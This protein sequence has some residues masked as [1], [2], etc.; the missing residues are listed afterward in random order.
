MRPI[1]VVLTKL[2]SAIDFPCVPH[3]ERQSS[4]D[5]HRSDVGPSCGMGARSLLSNQRI[6]P[7]E[8]RSLMSG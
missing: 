4:Q 8:C 3:V 7:P 5:N 6:S 2:R 1:L